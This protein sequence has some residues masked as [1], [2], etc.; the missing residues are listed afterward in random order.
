MVAVPL[1]PPQVTGPYWCT[2]VHPGGCF[3]T[4]VSVED[5]FDQ[6]DRDGWKW[7]LTQVDIQVVGNDLTATDPKC[8]ARVAELRACNCLLLEVNQIGSVTK[9]IQ[10]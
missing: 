5:P 8:I 7:F 4:V 10:A 6:D 3:P 1:P 2:R 9:S